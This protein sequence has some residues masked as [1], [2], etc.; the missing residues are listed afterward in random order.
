M[1]LRPRLIP[2]ILRL[3]RPPFVWLFQCYYWLAIQLSRWLVGRI[4]GVRSIYLSGSWVRRE[5]IYGLSDID[6]KIFVAGPKNQYTYQAIR[7]R[8]ALLR[9]FFPMLGPP[10]EKGIYFLDSFAA[11]YRHYPLMQHLF[12]ER[13]FKHRRIWGE[14]LLPILPLK[15]WIELDQGECCFFRLKDWLERVH[16]LADCTALTRQQKQHL[17]FKAV[18]DV[19]LLALRLDTPEFSFSER[20]EILRAI[21][22]QL[23]EP[24]RLQTDN[25]I[26]EHLAFYR[27][28]INGM[29]ENFQ[30]FKKMVA[31]CAAKASGLDRSDA[32]P[33]LSL[34]RVTPC[35]GNDPDQAFILQ[36]FSP[37]IRQVRV[38]IWPQLPL[39]PFDLH[40]FAAPV[41]LVE[42]SQPLSLEE[43]HNLKAYYRANLRNQTVVL[44]QEYPQ[45][46]SSVD[47]DLVD[48]WGSFSGS[49][50]IL[51]KVLGESASATLTHL[52][53]VRIATRARTFVD[54]LAATLAHREF[55]RMDPAIFPLFLFN[56]MRLVIFSLEFRQGLWRLPLTPVQVVEYLVEKTPLLPT[57]L[58]KL[59]EQ[60]EI[61]TQGQGRFDERLMPKCRALLVEMIGVQYVHSLDSL[62]R[63]NDLPDEVRLKISAAII[64]AK[65]P[66]QL[67][68]CLQSLLRLTRP[69]DELIVVDDGRD[70]STRRVVAEIRAPFPVRYV[71]CDQAGVAP[72]RN[73]A[74]RV[75]EG[76]IIAFVDDDAVVTP[77][78]LESLERVFL[79]DPHVGLAGG[80]VLNMR[81]G[82]ND[83]IWNFMEVVEKL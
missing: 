69:P 16:L 78:W 65:R 6:F 75:A 49:S 30:L 58:N 57:F 25:V 77:Q 12:D 55:G 14:D 28:H 31:I 13:F 60:Y 37:K 72:A 56:A 18:S 63:L 45:F 23:E 81:C 39:N 74:S 53:T 80:S 20:T 44:L 10:D 51:H 1:T 79:A 34:P 64:T 61:V 59:L 21:S 48:H 41:Y 8:F 73:L 9:R 33:V 11:D 68:R 47:T 62:G 17:F 24:Y 36:G 32:H 76:E 4:A 46:L 38:F 22:S 66:V 35:P 7:R 40:F 50:D 70:E 54:Q 3:H 52:E 71:T 2:L 29:D 82:R 5:V 15:T 19:G 67:E 83:L 42:C 43:F 26:R 27:V